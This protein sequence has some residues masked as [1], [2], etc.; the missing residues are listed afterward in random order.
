MKSDYNYIKIH[1]RREVRGKNY[2]EVQLRAELEK[3]FVGSR[4]VIFNLFHFMAHI[5]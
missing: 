4:P 5:N 3:G 1:N 2:G